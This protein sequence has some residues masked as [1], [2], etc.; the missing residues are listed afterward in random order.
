MARMLH[1]YKVFELQPTSFGRPKGMSTA[2]SI[3]EIK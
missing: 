3:Y 2:V 1:F